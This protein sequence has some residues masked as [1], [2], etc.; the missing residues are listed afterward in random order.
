MLLVAGCGRQDGP[1]P[2]DPGPNFRAGRPD[3]TKT[4]AQAR[5]GFQT[6]LLRQESAGQP[7]PEPPPRLFRLVRF[8]SPAGKLGAYL[9]P[10]PK[11]GKKHPAILWITGGD[12]NTIDDSV[13]KDAPPSNDQSASAF[14]KAGIVLMF[15]TLRGGNDNP[16]FR[17]GFF[18]EVEDVLAAA[19]YAA[20]QPYVDP[21][22]IYLGGHSTGGT[23]VLLT[24]EC[25]DRFR[26]VFSFGPA[27]DVRG[28]P[29]Q[30]I[31]FD[32]ND[33]RELELR[34]P[35]LW[36]HAIRSPVFVF[37]GTVDG[38]LGALQRMQ[39][40]STNPQVRFLPVTG[41]NHFNILAPTTR[42]IAQRIL[43]DDGPA[44]NIA[45][46]NEELDRPFAR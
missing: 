10:D 28:Y 33:R 26:A 31:P 42:L 5:Q 18:G 22:R 25:S 32:A 37:E 24:A 36:L 17:E 34:A 8:D 7:I 9:T 13:W 12:C 4:L 43:R 44:C 11:D 38:N 46:S 15:P 6:R 16:G 20:G 35:V 40:V 21:Q 29:P 30:Y 19:D 2:G 41:G 45:F 14:R 39:R 27:D 23:L 3:P 1:A